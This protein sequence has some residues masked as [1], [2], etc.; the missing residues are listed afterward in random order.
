MTP[1]SV[2]YQMTLENEQR[3]HMRTWQPGDDGVDYDD[4]PAGPVRWSDVAVTPTSRLVIWILCRPDQ[5]WR[6][7]IA[8][9]LVLAYL[10]LANALWQW[11]PPS[12]AVAVLAVLG[13]A[14]ALW[15]AVKFLIAS[16]AA[17]VM[18]RR[19]SRRGS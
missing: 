14:V 17:V 15:N 7:A 8:V 6:V 10:A 16:L 4:A 2:K 3:L 18:K 5:R 11:T 1:D 13:S 19:D 12:G 9:L